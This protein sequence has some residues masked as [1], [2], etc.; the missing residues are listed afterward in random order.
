MAI[1][2]IFLGHF[3]DRAW[4]LITPSQWAVDDR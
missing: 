1:A 2:N 3:G 4:Q